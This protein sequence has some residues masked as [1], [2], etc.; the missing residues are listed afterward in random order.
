MT[1]SNPIDSNFLPFPTAAKVPLVLS[2]KD[3]NDKL[4]MILKGDRRD[5]TGPIAAMAV[6]MAYRAKLDPTVLRGDT[7][8]NLEGR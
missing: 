6:R 8:D 3:V 5:P 1:Y 2:L 4:S 7:L